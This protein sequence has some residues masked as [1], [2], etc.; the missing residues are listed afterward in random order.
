MNA[1]V[2]RAAANIVIGQPD[3]ASFYCNQSAANSPAPSASTLS[4]SQDLQSPD[5][6]VGGVA[7]DPFGNLYVADS[8]NGRVLE[9][10]SPFTT[11]TTADRVFGPC[12]SFT[13]NQCSGRSAQSLT[14]PVGVAVDQ[15]GRLFASDNDNRVPGYSHPLPTSTADLV[16]G[17]GDFV[18]NLC[19][20]G[21]VTA[22]SMC[23][24]TG[25]GLDQSG[26]LFVAESSNNRVLEFAGPIVN[27]EKASGVF[28]Q[29]GSFTNS[30]CATG[31]D[32]MC[33][34]TGV[35]LDS[36]GDL[37]ALDAQNNRVL[38]YIAPFSASPLAALVVGQPNFSQKPC[39][40][41]GVSASSLCALLYGAR[42]RQ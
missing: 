16:V 26:D 30:T 11:D 31:Q 18:G 35:A 6:G 23:Q 38:E 24:P 1:L 5:E 42:C 22:G 2:N 7:V 20:N 9:Y 39:N 32:R 8:L 19:N 27:G 10:D 41:G 36:S 33:L 15:S 40:N 4:M 37:Y 14:K 3:F 28:G 13:S 21:G 29:L 12:G 25:I 34:P 17:Q